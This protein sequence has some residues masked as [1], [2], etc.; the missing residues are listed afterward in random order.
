MPDSASSSS[1]S[2][3]GGSSPF[4][5]PSVLTLGRWGR[6]RD[7]AASLAASRHLARLSRSVLLRQL[8]PRQLAGQQTHRRRQFGLHVGAVDSVRALDYRSVL[9]HRPAVC[10][11]AISLHDTA[12]PPPGRPATPPPDWF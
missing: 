10:A 5:S 6:R 12:G 9:V 3:S 11:L 2:T 4:H 1:A 8:R 7:G